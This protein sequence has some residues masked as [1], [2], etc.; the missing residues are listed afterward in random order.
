MGPTPFTL[1]ARNDSA[2][3]K[4]PV[5]RWAQEMEATLDDFGAVPP[6]CLVIGRGFSG[7]RGWLPAIVRSFLVPI[8]DHIQITVNEMSVAMPFYDM[9]IPL[10]GFDIAK[11]RR[12]RD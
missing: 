10:L 11:K 7:L 1:L 8:I 4:P 9:L 3:R 6:I 2:S 12:C 5:Y